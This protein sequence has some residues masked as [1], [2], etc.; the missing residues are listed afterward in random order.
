MVA[1]DK[2]IQEVCKY[3]NLDK[4]YYLSLE[5]TCNVLKKL[6]PK[7]EDFEL[8]VFTGNYI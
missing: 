8:S 2:S 4:L 5:K 3:L 6:N 7:L 1:N